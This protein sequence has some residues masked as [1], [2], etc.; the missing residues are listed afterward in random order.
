MTDIRK[1]LAALIRHRRQAQITFANP[2][3]DTLNGF[4]VRLG[5]KLLLLQSLV[6]FH[7]DGYY[8][9]NAADIQHLRS[10]KFERFFEEALRAEHQV[11][12]VADLKGIA[13][14]DWRS[15]L[16]AIRP[17][18]ENIIVEWMDDGELVFFAGQIARLNPTSLSFRQFDAEGKWWPPW[19]VPYEAIVN[20]QIRNEYINVISKHVKPWRSQNQAVLP[21]AASAAQADR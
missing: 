8:I 15:A 1:Q 17:T 6:D 7:F 4:P 18:G 14:Q 9:V 20:I 21:I 19:P 3:A 12:H 13:L 16:N 2:E 11:E 10:N 5:R